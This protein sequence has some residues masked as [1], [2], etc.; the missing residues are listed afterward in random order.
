M[1]GDLAGI[2]KSFQNT[3]VLVLGDF[4]LDEYIQGRADRISPEAP[5]P[6]VVERSR[7]LL[8]GGAGNVARNLLS[9]D[10]RVSLAGVIGRDEAGR[11]LKR[12]FEEL[13]V[14]GGDLLLES[15]SRPTTRKTRILAGNHQICRVDNEVV[16]LLDEETEQGLV[17]FIAREFASGTTRAVVISDYD[18]G[19][20]TPSLI[21]KTLELGREHDVII[22]VDPQIGHFSYYK[23][24]DILTP[25]HHEAGN[26]LGRKLGTDAEVEAGGR[27]ILNR[28]G[29]RRVL[30]TRGEKGMSLIGPEG[31]L[32][33]PT[34][35]RE[36]FDVTGAGDTVIA[37]V[38][39]ALAVG[40]SPEQAVRISNL[41]AGMVVARIGAAFLTREELAGAS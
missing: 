40:A 31:C 36:V 13:G 29:A 20:V 6:V 15:A 26:F 12:I 25:N 37:L 5:V 27:E 19:I 11:H 16:H 3:G 41:G 23:G 33:I 38:T 34:E 18:K 28:L 39:L 10:A 14:A 21:E 35:A 4:M 7:R 8:P 2:V 32:H 9:L 1:S 22:T 30:I 24:V 17:D